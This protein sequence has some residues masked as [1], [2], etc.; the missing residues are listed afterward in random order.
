MIIPWTRVTDLLDSLDNG[1]LMSLRRAFVQPLGL[2]RRETRS[3]LRVGVAGRHY[4]NE[5]SS[6]N[7]GCSSDE[8]VG[9]TE[10]EHC[11]WRGALRLYMRLR[12]LDV[13]QS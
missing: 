10:S 5:S 12:R 11:T 2:L 13:A 9:R 6:R 3:I 4:A 7:Y 8:D 1:L